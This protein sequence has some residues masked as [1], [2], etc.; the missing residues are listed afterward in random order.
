MPQFNRLP[1]SITGLLDNSKLAQTWNIVKFDI[2]EAQ[3][4]DLSL[5]ENNTTPVQSL[6]CHPVVQPQAQLLCDLEW[7]SVVQ[8][9]L[10]AA[11]LN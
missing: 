1:G 6:A 7:E 5:V 10:W 11:T 2:N 4:L 3:H 8:Q 9:A